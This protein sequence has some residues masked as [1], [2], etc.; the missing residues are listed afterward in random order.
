[1]ALLMLIPCRL[2]SDALSKSCRGEVGDMDGRCLECD[3]H[4]A[5]TRQRGGRV[6][7]LQDVAGAAEPGVEKLFLSYVCRTYGAQKRWALAYPASG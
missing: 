3:Q 5:R 7:E 1:M 6:D 2:T 4:F